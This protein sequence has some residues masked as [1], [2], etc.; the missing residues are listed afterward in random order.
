VGSV[1]LP[2]GAASHP[3]VAGRILYVV[4]AD[5]QLQAFR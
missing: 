2:G 1:D 5:G 3:V 4:S